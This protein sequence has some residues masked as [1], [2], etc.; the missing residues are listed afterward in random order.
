M[1]VEH[2]EKRDEKLDFELKSFDGVI[3]FDVFLFLNLNELKL[4]LSLSLS[5]ISKHGGC[6]LTTGLLMAV[7]DY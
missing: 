1:L 4:M 7:N 5:K 3:Y 2:I 6:F